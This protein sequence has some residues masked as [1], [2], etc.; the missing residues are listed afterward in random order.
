MKLKEAMMDGAEDIFTVEQIVKE[1]AEEA[2]GPC[3]SFLKDDC[4]WDDIVWFQSLGYPM[5]MVYQPTRKR[6]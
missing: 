3:R 6:A 1:A 2:P 5:E 4:T